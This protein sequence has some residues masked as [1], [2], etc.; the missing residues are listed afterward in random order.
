MVILD[1]NGVKKNTGTLRGSTGE[2]RRPGPPGA[3]QIE[4]WPDRTGN[5]AP[6]GPEVRVRDGLR[7]SPASQWRWIF[8]MLGSMQPNMVVPSHRVNRILIPTASQARW[9]TFPF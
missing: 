3:F 4:G 1:C 8:G 2:G 9:D 5:P 7:P 6:A